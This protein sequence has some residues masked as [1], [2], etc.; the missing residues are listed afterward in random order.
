MR[1]VAIVGTE[2]T[3]QGS[4]PWEDSSWE[5]WACSNAAVD[6]PRVDH[7]FEIHNLEWA[8]ERGEDLDDWL[9]KA[10]KI[11][12]IWVLRPTRHFPDAKL[13]PYVELLAHF[14]PYFFTSTIAWMM[15]KAIHE[16]VDV[17][18]MFGV[19]MSASSE[20]GFQRPGCQYFLQM[21]KNAKITVAAPLEA[22]ILQEPPSYGLQEFEP[23]YRKM[24]AAASNA[25]E[26]LD[27]NIHEQNRLIQGEHHLRGALE[28]INY[29][30]KTFSLVNK[31]QSSQ[32]TS[33][34]ILKA[35]E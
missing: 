8:L 6:Y 26:R 34:P 33:P 4:P 21:C 10:R 35:V 7:L 29:D 23:F 13:I 25:K 15:A 12:N 3:S 28:R 2:V 18:G 11:N 9:V 27:A 19:S 1:K 24:W 32:P 30:M 22:D 20:Y 31:G 14:G 17:L 5:I 16:K